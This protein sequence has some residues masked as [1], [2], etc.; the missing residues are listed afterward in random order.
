MVE[1]KLERDSTYE[2]EFE[3]AIDI[4]KQHN[5]F[6]LTTHVNP[7]GDGLGSESAL[8][9]AL[10]SMGK[11]VMV[12]NANPTPDLYYFLPEREWFL[13]EVPHRQQHEV[14]IF[15]E[16]PDEERSGNAVELPQGAKYVINIDHHVYNSRYGT[17]NLIDPTAA[18]AG[19]QVW[20]L[21]C[22]LDCPRNKRMAIGIYTAIATDTGHFKYAGVTSRTHMIIAQLLELGVQPSYMS[23]QIYER[24]PSEGLHL[25]ALGLCGVQYNA[26]RNVGWFTVSQDMLEKTGTK[27]NYTENFV[28]YV[29]AVEGVE[30][31][32]FFL[33]TSFRSRGAVDVSAIAHQFGGGGH[34]R[35]AGA[36]ISG[37]LSEVQTQVLAAVETRVNGGDG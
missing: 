29:R 17:V 27:A 35:A 10:K 24:V 32:V 23:E 16:C 9:V 31:A 12:V 22:A 34:Q 5:D 15:L 8:Y 19:E 3:R 6:V 26:R 11:K 2:R 14:A 20:E 37:A 1:Q 7:D 28:N 36:L 33:E 18:A 25:L 4:I 13:V 21:L 30:V